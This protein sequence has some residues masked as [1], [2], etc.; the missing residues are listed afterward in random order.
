AAQHQ[1]IWRRVVVTGGGR[2]EHNDSFGN[3]GVPRV[4]GVV[5][6]HDADGPRAAFGE[7]RLRASA[8]L[9]IKEP[10]ILQS[11]SPSPFSR[12]NPDLRPEKS[13]TVDVGID[14]RLAADRVR[15]ELTWFDNRYR[16]LISTRTTNPATFVAAYF[17]IG[18]TRARGA[19]LVGDAAPV[20]GLHIR[21]GYTFLDSE[22]IDST[23]PTSPV[24]RAG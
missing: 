12:G 17:N 14:Q 19:E 5:V 4:S 7:T 16:N 1:A 20:G 3:A 23:S 15:V 21:G 18:N 13:R 6:A 24:L 10:T 11:F 2:F 8:G 9:G 22:I